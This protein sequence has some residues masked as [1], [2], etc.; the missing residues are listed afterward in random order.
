[1]GWLNLMNLIKG[2]FQLSQDRK[3]LLMK[4]IV[5]TLLIRTFLYIFTFSKIQTITHR[6]T[7]TNF[8]KK[9]P[10][11]TKD[12]IWSVK[13]ASNYIP[14][15]TCLVQ[16]ITA[17]LFLTYNGYDSTLKIGVIKSD[18]F[19][20]HAWIE[21]NNVIVLGDSDQN[22]VPLLDLEPKI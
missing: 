14:K 11:S 20:A 19:E 10:K 16:A 17:Q 7:R 21:I 3:S 5:L 9:N 15:A 6:L 2:F 12:I 13:V 1:M 18:N 22:F 4:S 8:H